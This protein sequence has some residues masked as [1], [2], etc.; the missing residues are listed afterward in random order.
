M[1][2]FVYFS[3]ADVFFYFGHLLMHKVKNSFLHSTHML[4]HS[5]SA[6]CA[7]SGYYMSPLDFVLEHLHVFVA[8]YMWGECGPAWAVAICV[9]TFNLLTTHSGWDHKWF[10]DPIPHYLHHKKHSCNFGIVLDHL[11][12]TA[13]TDVDYN[14]WSAK[15]KGML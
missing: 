6:L 12:A 1:W 2:L 3:I 13:H 10:P 15:L 9:G 4:H 8:F 5:S 7:I 11:F 14:K